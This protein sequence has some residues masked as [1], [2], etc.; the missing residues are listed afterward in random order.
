MGGRA[1]APAAKAGPDARCT[2]LW[3]IGLGWITTRASTKMLG[4]IVQ[5]SVACRNRERFS[6]TE[7]FSYL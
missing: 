7:R 1:G 5:A 3:S 6:L 2:D 4:K